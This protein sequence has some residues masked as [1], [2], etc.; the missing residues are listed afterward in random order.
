MDIGNVGNAWKDVIGGVGIDRK[1]GVLVVGT[2]AGTMTVEGE[3]LPSQVETP[4]HQVW[5]ARFKADGTL[6]WAKQVGSNATGNFAAP[7]DIADLLVDEDDGVLIA[8]T[9]FGAFAFDEE[10]ISGPESPVRS[11]AFLMRLKN[12]G[13]FDWIRQFVSD[14][15]GSNPGRSQSYDL[16]FASEGD[17]L[18]TGTVRGRANLEQGQWAFVGGFWDT[19]DVGETT[20]VSIEDEDAYVAVYAPG[21]Y[22]IDF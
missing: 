16:N 11:Y 19:M 20:I 4:Q 15:A 5:M 18:W 21:E 3:E 7:I 2:K 1:G 8:G 17:I 13:T 9:Q 12:D 22:P 14:E 6:D 10:E